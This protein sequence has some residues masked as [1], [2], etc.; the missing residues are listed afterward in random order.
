M[1]EKNNIRENAKEKE[2]Q[3][4]GNLWTTYV[5]LSLPNHFILK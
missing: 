5:I 4:T 3:D 2:E 1:K